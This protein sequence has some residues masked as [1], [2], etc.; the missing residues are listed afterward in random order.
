MA[1]QKAIS[2]WHTEEAQYQSEYGHYASSLA[3]LGPPSSGTPSENGADLIYRQLA[4]GAKGNFKFT[5]HASGDG[6]VITASPAEFGTS[7][8]H[9][10]YSDQSMT[11]HR[12]TGPETATVNDPLVGESEP[13]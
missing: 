10:Y 1:A 5:L 9:T 12:H 4:T 3:Q 11:L 6:Y 8:S 7:G 2:T 13:K